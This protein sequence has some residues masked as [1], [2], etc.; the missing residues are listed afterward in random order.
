MMVCIV[1]H[2]YSLLSQRLGPLGLMVLLAGCAGSI[3]YEA[4]KES[5]ITEAYSWCTAA[6]VKGPEYHACV[7]TLAPQ[8]YQGYISEINADMASRRAALM[9]LYGIQ[10]ASR[11]STVR[12]KTN[13]YGSGSWVNCQ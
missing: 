12:L 6:E 13:C 7:A 1:G 2:G 3:D 11:P 10:Q 5:S 8:I 4:L 9:Q